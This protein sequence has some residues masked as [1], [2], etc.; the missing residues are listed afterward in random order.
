M[1]KTRTRECFL[2]RLES[3]VAP[4]RLLIDEPMS[5]HT[6]FKIG[7]P[8]DYLVLPASTEEVAAVLAAA[9]EYHVPVTVLGNGSNVLVR[10]KGIRGLVLKFGETLGHI[11][12]VGTT[13][14]AGAGAALGDVVRYGASQG[15][16][17]LEF[18]VGIP[19]SIG[20]AVFM[21]AGAYE[22]EVGCMVAAVTAV[23]PSGHLKRFTHGEI[24][25]GYR[26]SIFQHNECI[27]CEVEL[28]LAVGDKE[29]IARQIDEYTHKREAKQPIEKPSAGSTFKRPPGHFAGTLIEQAGLKGC[30]FGGAQV[31]EKHAGFIINAG[32]ATATD[33]LSLI[34]EVQRQVNA[35]YG[36]KLQP[37][38][39][40][41]GEE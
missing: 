41:I 16:I 4:D 20:G 5:S 2:S 9:E 31:S 25:F 34:K 39:R 24:A 23:S 18:A 22:G 32:G 37:E 15:L 26:D 29:A 6:T 36:V 38:V 33:V 17:G 8:A 35:K 3:V 1:Q 30:K 19:G 28:K 27:I 12:H 11:R 40:I 14:V 13:V 10:D 21:N 7:G